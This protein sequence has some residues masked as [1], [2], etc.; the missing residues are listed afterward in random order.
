MVFSSMT[1]LLV[2]LPL[3]VILYYLPSFF[4]KKNNIAYRNIILCAA[5]LIFYAYGEPVCIVLLV[6]SVFVN[7]IFGNILTRN[8]NKAILAL[9]VGLNLLLL[10]FYIVPHI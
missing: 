9:A 6:G 3:T 5:S 1:F 10:I 8:K 4:N 7:L 2:F